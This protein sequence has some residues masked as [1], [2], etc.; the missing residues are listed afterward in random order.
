MDELKWQRFLS[1]SE[2]G[3]AVKN[4]VVTLSGIVDSYSKKF[5][6]EKAAKKVAG[7]KPVALDMQ[8]GIS[9]SY[10]KTDAEIAQAIVNALRWQPGVQEDKTKVEVE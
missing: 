2:I 10:C 1:S 4:G 8:V 5:T 7:V 3:M 6:A 9:P